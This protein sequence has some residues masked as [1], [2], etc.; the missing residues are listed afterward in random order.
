MDGRT[1]DSAGRNLLDKPT[2]GK[3]WAMNVLLHSRPGCASMSAPADVTPRPD[4]MGCVFRGEI[5]GEELKALTHGTVGST[6][7]GSFPS[8]N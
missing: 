7:E 3:A 6:P 1:G 5:T 2:P 8:D 4:G